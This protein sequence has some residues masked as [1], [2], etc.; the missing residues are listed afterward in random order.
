MSKP[1]CPHCGTDLEFVAADAEREPDDIMTGE[2]IVGDRIWHCQQ[3]ERCFHQRVVCHWE[4]V[5]TDAGE[6]REEPA[7]A[8]IDT[9]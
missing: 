4:C 1:A 8:T 9:N 3:C 5:D 7:V 6:L 2:D